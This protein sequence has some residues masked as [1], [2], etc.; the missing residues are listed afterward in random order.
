MY[1]L[2]KLLTTALLLGTIVITGAGL[3]IGSADAE[4]LAPLKTRSITHSHSWADATPP[5][6]SIRP[7]GNFEPN[8]TPITRG[9]GST[10]AQEVGVRITDASVFHEPRVFPRQTSH[11]A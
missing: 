2:T 9:P 5:S 11:S 8:G 6:Q 3:V 4:T 1:L 10:G 7:D